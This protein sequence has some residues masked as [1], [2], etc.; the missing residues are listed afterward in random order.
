MEHTLDAVGDNV[1]RVGERRDILALDGGDE[2]ADQRVVDLVD[3][4]VGALLDLVHLGD[5]VLDLGGVEVTHDIVQLLCR[6]AGELCRLC[7]AV[8]IECVVLFCHDGSF[9]TA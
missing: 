8:V 3:N 6:L 9:C 1:E 2:C 4:F 5:G 7:E